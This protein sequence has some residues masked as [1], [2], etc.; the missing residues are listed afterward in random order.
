MTEIRGIEGIGT[1]GA[2]IMTGTNEQERAYDGTKTREKV[3]ICKVC[4]RYDG[5]EPSTKPTDRTR[6]RGA[7]VGG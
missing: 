6:D 2:K 3:G 4:S 1:F 7:S 5:C